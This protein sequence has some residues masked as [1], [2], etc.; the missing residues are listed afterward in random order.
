MSW[1]NGEVEVYFY[2]STTSTLAKCVV[3]IRQNAGQFPDSYWE[4]RR[5]EKPQPC[6]S[7]PTATTSELFTAR[8]IT[9]AN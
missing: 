2:T 9:V 8:K 1:E 4:R 5:S 7:Q 3:G 6:G